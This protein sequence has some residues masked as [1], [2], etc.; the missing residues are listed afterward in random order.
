MNNEPNLALSPVAACAV[1]TIATL[2]AVVIKLDFL[3]HAMQ[4][5]SEAH[6]GRN[7]LLMPTEA[8]KLAQQILAVCAEL[9]AGPIPSGPGLQH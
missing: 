1:S 3:S 5:A 2:G 7:Y 9:E 8:R 6:P 4:S